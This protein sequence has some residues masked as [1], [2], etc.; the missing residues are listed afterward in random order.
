LI[1]FGHVLISLDQLYNAFPACL[2]PVLSQEL[3]VSRLIS[4]MKNLDYK[5]VCGK[6]QYLGKRELYRGTEKEYFD[7]QNVELGKKKKE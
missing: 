4:I 7:F 6:K 5:T 2:I 1:Y 3:F